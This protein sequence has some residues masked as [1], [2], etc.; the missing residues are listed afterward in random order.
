MVRRVVP[1]LVVGALGLL[2]AW[3]LMS[4][5]QKA[6][7]Q[8]LPQ[9]QATYIGSS[10]CK[11]CHKG[12]WESWQKTKHAKLAEVQI[13]ETDLASDEYMARHTTGYD[14]ATKKG[15]E[16]G[17]AC[18]MCHGPGSLHM[19]ASKEERKAMIFDPVRD[20][21]KPEV[22]FSVCAQCHA[23]YA[24]ETGERFA[25]GFIP[26]QN[27][28]PKLKFDAAKPGTKLEQFN[29]MQ[30]SKHVEKG[31]VCVKCH[32]GHVKDEA[33]LKQLRKP[34]IETCTECHT[35]KADIKKHQPTAKDTD[36]C[37]TCHMPDGR[38]VFRTPKE[39]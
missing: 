7:D 19:K 34:I 36:T 20:G 15:V 24:L 10:K 38:H 2:I 6:D 17:V 39:M 1:G 13:A 30:G 29:E 12:Q 5:D 28:L 16:T 11:M 3:P 27:L 26:G 4:E 31:T 33:L 18:E 8:A 21:V 22:A 23:Q 14:P 32:T 9:A 25:K 37:A 35:D